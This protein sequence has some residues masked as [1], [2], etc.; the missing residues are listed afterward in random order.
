MPEDV[1]R[2]RER[3]DDGAAKHVA[4]EGVQL[5]LELGDDTKVSATSAD[6]PEEIRFVVG[7][8]RP[9]PSVRRDDGGTYDIVDR[10]PELAVEP[11]VS[12]AEGVSADAGMR[13]DARR[14]AEPVLERRRIE[15]V[16]ERSA[17]CPRTPRLRIDRD[18][19]HL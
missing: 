14:R 3:P 4:V 6:R 17:A 8:D 12:A 18:P 11:P 5:V 13:Y 1:A 9:N 15:R 16:E 2:L 7:A 19:V 10:E